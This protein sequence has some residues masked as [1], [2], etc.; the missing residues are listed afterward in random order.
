ME[1]PIELMKRYLDRRI[2]ELD[3]LKMSVSKDDYSGALK[4]GHMVKGNATTFNLPLVAPYGQAIESAAKM[5]D[6]DLLQS[7]F[8]KM[9][10][11][12]KEARAEIPSSDP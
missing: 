11:I 6:K 5:R 10:A 7:L 1:V 4:L 9:E 12:V 8:R 2:Q 3:R